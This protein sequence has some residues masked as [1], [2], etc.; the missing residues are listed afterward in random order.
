MFNGSKQVVQPEQLE[1]MYLR[2]RS[3]LL[4]RCRSLLSA[5]AEAED[6]LQDTFVGFMTCGWRGEA[7]PLTVLYR[8]ATN[9]AIT[10]LRRRGKWFEVPLPERDEESDGELVGA[11]ERSAPGDRVDW[12]QA[13]AFL[14][15]GEDPSLLTAARMYWVEGYALEEVAQTFAVTRKTISA[16]LTRLAARVAVRRARWDDGP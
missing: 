13:L 8:V 11:L 16:R 10:R 12:A 3:V 5:E 6:C 7:Q 15:Q 9:Q 1:A 14:T 4:R 2:Y